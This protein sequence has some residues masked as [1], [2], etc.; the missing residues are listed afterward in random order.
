MEMCCVCGGGRA[1]DDNGDDDN[2]DDGNGDD[3]GDG[4]NNQSV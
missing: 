1:L 3:G 2:G 4:G